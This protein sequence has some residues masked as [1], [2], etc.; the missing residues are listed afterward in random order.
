MEHLTKILPAID[1][2]VFWI[3]RDPEYDRCG[4]IKF[5]I[6]IIC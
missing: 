4:D 6:S 1:V 2:A 5:E 3:D